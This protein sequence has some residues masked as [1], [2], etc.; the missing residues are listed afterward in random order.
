[1][2]L[3]RRQ[4]GRNTLHLAAFASIEGGP[5]GTILNLSEA[6]IGLQTPIPAGGREFASKSDVRLSLELPATQTSIEARGVVAWTD[7]SGRSGVR[8][9]NLADGPRRLVREF[10]A[11]NAASQQAL[12]VGPPVQSAVSTDPD[13][14]DA[15]LQVVAERARALTGASG[16][17]VAILD[18]DALVCRAISGELV[19]PRGTRLGLG[20]GITAEC[21][22]KRAVLRCDDAEDDPGVDRESCRALG[23]RSIVVVPV[24]RGTQVVGVLEIVSATAH[25]FAAY[26]QTGLQRVIDQIL[27]GRMPEKTGPATPGEPTATVGST[28]FEQPTVTSGDS[29][30]ISPEEG[31]AHSRTMELL[32]RLRQPDSWVIRNRV[33]LGAVSGTILGALVLSV[34]PRL[35]RRAVVDAQPTV[36][37]SNLE[38]PS[39]TRAAVPV[40]LRKQTTSGV[41]ELEK[42]ARSGDPEAQF[43]LGARYATGDQ[44]AQDY[45]QAAKWFMRSAEQGHVAAQAALGACYWAGRGVGQDYVKSYMWSSLAKLGGDEASKYRVGVLR[46]RM[47]TVQVAEAQSLVQS[48]LR[49]HPQRAARFS[50]TAQI[51]P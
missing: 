42:R 33:V 17:A 30:P 32:N 25:A 3:E 38:A 45:S 16:A 41:S 22:R 34:S 26:D 44:V 19:P 15:A 37:A 39:T 28:Q 12:V 1:M 7:A 27:T 13:I 50:S 43:S 36:T 5:E 14:S 23:I 35:Q 21:V 4:T 51:Q 6:G 46:P 29:E 47:S 11:L 10:L 40:E 18:G 8:F 48:W 31:S 49:G 24:N 9:S 20:S 2:T